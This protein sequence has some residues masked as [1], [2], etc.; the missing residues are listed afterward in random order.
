MLE[1]GNFL[2]SMVPDRRVSPVARDCG[3]GKM[4]VRVIEAAVGA[5]FM[6]STDRTTL[7]G[8]VEVGSEC[9]L[10]ACRDELVERR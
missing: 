7:A 1:T 3:A 8:D 6:R 4:D 5:P 2:G 9:A 10:R